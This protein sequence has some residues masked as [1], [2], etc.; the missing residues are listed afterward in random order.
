MKAAAG[1]FDFLLNTIPV[2]H[3]VNPYLALLKRD[4]T[5][6]M[7]GVLTA[8]EPPVS[9]ASLIGGRK[10]LTGSGI[11]G[12]AETQEMIDFCAAHNIVSDIEMVPIQKVNE[13]YERVLKND[14]K[15]RFVIDIA[16][17]RQAAA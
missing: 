15:Y 2:G 17:L 9:G 6:V 1:S 16:S 5:M 3:D 10:N 12:M 11:G 7:V 4:S 8:I 13:A 14:V